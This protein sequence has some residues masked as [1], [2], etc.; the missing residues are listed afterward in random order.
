MQLAVT[1]G[2]DDFSEPAAAAV[3]DATPA[4]LGM[5]D[6]AYKRGINNKKDL[7]RALKRVSDFNLDL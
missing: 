4:M 7:P 1:S 5:S 6:V 2:A 3:D